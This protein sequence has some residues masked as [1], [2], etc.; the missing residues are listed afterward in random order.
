MTITM[1]L[2]I[3]YWLFAFNYS[4]LIPKNCIFAV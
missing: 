2:A 1:T 3:G 4:T